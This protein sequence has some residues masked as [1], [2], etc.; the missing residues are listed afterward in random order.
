MNTYAAKRLSEYHKF[1]KLELIQIL[2]DALEKQPASY[3]QKPSSNPLFDMG[4][5][6]NNCLKWVDYKGTEDDKVI[7]NQV[8]VIRVLQKFSKYSKVQLPKKPKKPD[9]IYRELPSL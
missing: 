2:K 8:V 9:I 3:W 4:S 1:T 7:P 6:F 5:Y